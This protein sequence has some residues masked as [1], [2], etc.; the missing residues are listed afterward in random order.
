M[1]H[2]FIVFIKR[3]IIRVICWFM[4]RRFPYSKICFLNCELKR[5]SAEP[6]PGTRQGLNWISVSNK[7]RKECSESSEVI[8]TLPHL[9]RRCNLDSSR[10]FVKFLD[11]DLIKT[12]PCK[13][14]S[15]L[16]II[17]GIFR[18]NTVEEF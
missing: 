10:N 3:L 2:R 11:F 14:T 13:E 5:I 9:S 7:D 8:E 1:H 18:Y 15:N 4:L 16:K 6:I 12:W 17:K